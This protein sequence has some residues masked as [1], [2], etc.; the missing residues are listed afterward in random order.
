MSEIYKTPSI[1]EIEQKMLADI[2][3]DYVKGTGTFTT[4][5]IRTYAIE[6]NRIEQ[7][8]EDVYNKMNVYNLYGEELERYVLQRKGVKRK[9]ANSAIGIL[10]AKGNGVI[11]QG[12]FFETESGTR[13]KAK[14]RIEIK[15]IGKV[16]IEAVE[17]GN[18]GN[19]GANTITLIPVT[20]QGITEVTNQEP[21]YDGYDIETE[22]S[23][24]ERYL[25]E[26]Q[27]PATSGNRYHYTQWAREVVGVG[28]SKIFS[29]WNGNNTVQIVIIDDNKLPAT[30]ELVERTQEYIDPKGENDIT[31]GTGVGQAPIGAYCTVISAIG[32]NIDINCT[33]VLKKGYTVDIIKPEIEKEIKKYLKEI[34]FVKN[35]VS[36]ALLASWI[37]NVEGVVEWTEF[38]INGG[39]SNIIIEEKEVAIMGSVIINV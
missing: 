29:L 6:T 13:F 33:L 3:N 35:Y 22:D 9:A 27:K 15:D 34:A 16:N 4:D 5:L 25:I 39:H 24:R 7:K 20:I 32:K 38:T 23:L 8:V 10:T 12:D 30:T 28:D 14:E 11:E 19:V 2:S 1:S 18:S 26:V 37:L 21:T 31:W 36:Y 17:A